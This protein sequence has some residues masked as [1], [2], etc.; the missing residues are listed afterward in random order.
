M[1]LGIS[2]LARGVPLC[3]DCAGSDATGAPCSDHV[4]GP[5]PEC[6]YCALAVLCTPCARRLWARRKTLRETSSE[7]L[8]RL[9]R[10]PHPAAIALG[11]VN[12]RGTQAREALA[13]FAAQFDTV[14]I[15][16]AAL[17]VAARNPGAG[18]FAG[19]WAAA[20]R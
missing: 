18:P 3:A 11:W 4:R 5:A 10:G 6:W 2:G 12:P 16:R 8:A 1:K 17:D 15:G 7:R 20:L 9:A 14:P 19:A 13:A